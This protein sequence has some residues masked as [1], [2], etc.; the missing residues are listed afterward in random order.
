[1]TNKY[2][3][4]FQTYK[5]ELLTALLSIKDRRRLDDFLVDLLTPQEYID[6]LKRW[7][8]VKRLHRGEHQRHIAKV[9]NIGIAK[10]TRGSRML[11][12]KSGGFNQVLRKLNK[13]K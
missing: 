6:I 7:Q 8:L 10:I 5:K 1:M 4:S 2:P 12:N 13:K 11:L 9:L 3:V